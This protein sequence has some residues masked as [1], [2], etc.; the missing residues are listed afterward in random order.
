[1][2]NQNV[3]TWNVLD[4]IYF[5]TFWNTTAFDTVYLNETNIRLQKWVCWKVI[6]IKKGDNRKLK[7]K[8]KRNVVQIWCINN[9]FVNRWK[10][11]VN[12]ISLFFSDKS[13]PID[14]YQGNTNSHIISILIFRIH[15]FFR[16]LFERCG[17][18]SF[19]ICERKK[20]LL[21]F[22]C[23]KSVS[24]QQWSSHI[25]QIETCVVHLFSHKTILQVKK[26]EIKWI[27]E[28]FFRIK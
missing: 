8:R 23:S 25:S 17:F 5:Q 12:V 21:F 24:L 28:F 1:M 13:V 16:N 9:L 20:E 27:N 15:V 10:L 11:V 3:T 7:K 14:G 26:K 2:K 22:V 19:W 4:Q 6:D 18:C